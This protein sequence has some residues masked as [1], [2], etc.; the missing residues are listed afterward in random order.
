MA[1]AS[2]TIETGINH[3]KLV[4]GTRNSAR[5]V[6][7]GKRSY[8]FRFST[9]LGNFPVGRTDETLNV[10]NI[11]AVLDEKAPVTDFEK[12]NGWKKNW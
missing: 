12:E 6:P 8:L 2:V 10:K 1:A 11:E 7:T 5:N 9:F 3:E 4:N